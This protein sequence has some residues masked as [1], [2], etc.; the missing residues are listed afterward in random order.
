MTY[1]TARP[2]WP[3]D[4]P[5]AAVEASLHEL[6]VEARRC[7]LMAMVEA[8]TPLDV[9]SLAQL[10]RDNPEYALALAAEAGRRFDRETSRSAR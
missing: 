9:L 4:T 7:E 1:P 6:M 3:S 2:T 5:M 10:R 8:A